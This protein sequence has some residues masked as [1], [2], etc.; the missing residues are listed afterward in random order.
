M[1]TENLKKI[2][3]KVS[4]D[5][6]SERV[7]LYNEIV[8]EIFRDE[9]FQVEQIDRLD[10]EEEIDA[11]LS[12]L[13]STI[14]DESKSLYIPFINASIKKFKNDQGYIPFIES[15][16][17]ARL[18]VEKSLVGLDNIENQIVLEKEIIELSP[19]PNNI[20]EVLIG[21]I[22]IEAITQIV[23]DKS[24]ENINLKDNFEESD[25][26]A[27]KYNESSNFNDRTEPELLHYL[28]SIDQILN[29]LSEHFNQQKNE[30]IQTRSIRLSNI[31]QFNDE[32]E[33]IRK[34]LDDINIKYEN[35]KAIYERHLSE[36]QNVFGNLNHPEVNSEFLKTKKITGVQLEKQVKDHT[37]S[38]ESH[39]QKFDEILKAIVE[40]REKLITA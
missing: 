8:L 13:K 26:L 24:F 31:M 30:L 9:M 10:R 1:A 3:N 15:V 28:S 39:L 16:K 35:N 38:I 6:I 21:E 23:D 37:D 4:K 5:S 18:E 19:L 20:S 25:E 40:T 22:K 7:H 27:K 29:N 11:V 2:I 36:N 34:D 32:I 12:F 14:S 17:E 33:R